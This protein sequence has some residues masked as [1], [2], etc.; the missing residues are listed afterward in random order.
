VPG[1]GQ[2]PAGGEAG[3]PGPD[4]ED[5]HRR[6]LRRLGTGSTADPLR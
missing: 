6:S 1:P 3:D 4:D 5:P 2:C